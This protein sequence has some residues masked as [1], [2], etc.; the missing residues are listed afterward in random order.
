MKVFS[1]I[2]CS[3]AAAGACVGATTTASA[4]GVHCDSDDG[5]DITIVAG[6]TACRATVADSGHARAVGFDGVGYAKATAGAMAL[7]V[8]ASGGIGA[9][10]G[11]TGVPVAIG[12]GPNAVALTSLDDA[13]G[14]GRV[15]LSV[16]MSGS[17]AQVISADRSAACLGTVALAWDSR[18][19]ATCLATPVGIWRTPP[20]ALP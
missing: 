17:A 1:A 9:S 20:A 18:T 10:E 19:G 6:A 3:A 5:G 7:G 15:G 14:A 12:L 2:L 16:A 8:G 11:T 13:A 4:T